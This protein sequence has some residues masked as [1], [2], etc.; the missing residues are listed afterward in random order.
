[1]KKWTL[2]QLAEHVKGSVHGDPKAV[3]ESIAT[4][5]SAQA[6]DISFLANKKYTNLLA[7]TKATAIVVAK[8]IKSEA[9]LLIADDPYFA[10]SQIIILMHG[11]RQHPQT[12]ISDKASISD[13]A[14]VG[15]N[16]QIAD[17]VTVSANASLGDN[18]VLYPGVFVGADTKI[19]DNCLLYPNA[20]VYD[21]CTIG[22]NCIIHANATIGEDGF[23]FATHKGNHHKIPHVG[24]VI[25]GDDVEIGANACIERGTI[26]DTVIG[27]GTKIGDSVV[28]G[29]GTRIG[30]YCL[31]VPQVGIAGSA[32]M[33]DYC[34]VGGQAGIVGHIKIG[35]QVQIAA[36]AAVINDIPDGQT[37]VGSPAIDASKA[38]RAYSLIEYLPEMRKKIKDLE[39]RLDSK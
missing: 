10:F 34:A 26:N 5:E 38:K 19:S 36:Q 4:L 1:M 29:H 27:Q 14:S 18:C 20:V 37:V 2:G 12:G 7:T 24:S 8:E 31:L 11:H 25:L 16:C 39:K 33:G 13:S 35:N 32:V 15:K 22:K 17:F 6:G 28:I 9:N 21:K 23:G 3:I 30:R